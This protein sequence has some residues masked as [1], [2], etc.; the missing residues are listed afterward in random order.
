MQADHLGP[1]P[2]GQD[3]RQQ[4]RPVPPAGHGVRD[5]REEPAHLVGSVSAGNRLDGSAVARPHRR[6]WRRPGPSGSGSGRS[7]TGRRSWRRPS[8]PRESGRT[9]RCRGRRPGRRLASPGRASCPD[10]RRRAR[11]SGSRTRRSVWSQSGCP[12]R[13]GRRR[14]PGPRRR[15]LRWSGRGVVERSSWAPRVR[16]GRPHDSLARAPKATRSREA[17]STFRWGLWDLPAG[18]LVSGSGPTPRRPAGITKRAAGAARFVCVGPGPR[19]RC[20]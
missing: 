16:D 1:P 2:A 9:C 7:W 20:R 15:G 13:P 5:D 18:L 11:A 6:G 17:L 8:W 14:G 4:D 10:R 19:G 3:Q 12:S